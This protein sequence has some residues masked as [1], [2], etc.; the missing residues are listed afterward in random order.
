MKHDF[1]KNKRKRTRH[2]KKKNKKSLKFLVPFTKLALKAAMVAGFIFL[3]GVALKA[4][5]KNFQK[6]EYFYVK[7][8]V[9]KGCEKS[10]ESDLYKLSGLDEKTSMISLDLNKLSRNIQRHPW[11]KSVSVKKQLPDRIMVGINEREPVAMV[12]LDNL[13]YVDSGSVVFKRLE[14]GDSTDFLVITG[15][16]QEEAFS[17]DEDD[18]ALLSDALSLIEMLKER[19]TFSD[20][21][22][23]EINLDSVRGITLFTY[24]GAMPIKVGHN[25]SHDR[26]NKLLRVMK[27]LKKK[28]LLAEYIDIDYDKKVVVKIAANG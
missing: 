27:E 23:S 22:I 5:Y 21:D 14:K 4:L 24:N 2:F 28:S 9:F 13:Y 10:K 16:T 1:N 26:F 17:D 3:S 12:N 20:K 8:M 25:F 18:K 19:K 11:V 6:V 7:K 15:L